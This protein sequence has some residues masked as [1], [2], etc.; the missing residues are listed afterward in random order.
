MPGPRGAAR[1]EALVR[2]RPE[3]PLEPL[4][5]LPAVRATR[6][7]QYFYAEA[8]QRRLWQTLS[9]HYKR[10]GGLVSMGPARVLTDRARAAWSRSCR[11]AWALASAQ[12]AL[13][14]GRDHA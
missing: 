11:A 12:A 1:Q 7:G 2:A 9:A 13:P 5:A 14:H 6:L 8:G 10:A 3:P 4:P